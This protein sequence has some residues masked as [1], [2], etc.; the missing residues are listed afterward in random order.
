M[1]E[2]PKGEKLSVRHFPTQKPSMTSHCLFNQVHILQM[3]TQNL[4]S[5]GPILSCEITSPCTS[6]Y[7]ELCTL[8]FMSASS[9][10][11]L[12]RMSFPTN[13]VQW[14]ALPPEPLLPKMPM[15]STLIRIVS[16]SPKSQSYQ[17]RITSSW[18]FT[19][20]A[21]HRSIALFAQFRFILTLI[22]QMGKLSL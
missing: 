18:T 17:C 4:L 15:E 12:S 14:K 11:L 6:A 10:E 16:S 21:R 20:Q 7:H 22:S 5:I 9:S 3:G 19:A 8:L 13:S 2:L 1:G